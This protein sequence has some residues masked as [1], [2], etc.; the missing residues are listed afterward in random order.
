L[1][2]VMHNP[3][4]TAIVIGWR[5]HGARLC[6]RPHSCLRHL[7]AAVMYGSTVAVHAPA[8]PVDGF[9]V[10]S[11]ACLVV[12][13]SCCALIGMIYHRCAHFS[14]SSL[15]VEDGSGAV[16]GLASKI[17]DNLCTVITSC[18]LFVVRRCHQQTYSMAGS[19]GGLLQTPR[20]IHAWCLR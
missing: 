14:A 1:L 19:A 7:R 15:S 9:H 20:P 8:N 2:G 5:C 4:A 16:Q 6:L 17:T 18:S 10:W 12:T 3:M 11:Y 13:H